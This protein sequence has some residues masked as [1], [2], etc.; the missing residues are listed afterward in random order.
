MTSLS[1]ADY[2]KSANRE[3]GVHEA[4]SHGRN[5][6]RMTSLS[7]EGLRGERSKT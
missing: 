3:Y 4:H 7:K 1:S 6:A 5:L 2:R